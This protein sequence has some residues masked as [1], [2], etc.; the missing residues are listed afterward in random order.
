MSEKNS[1]QKTPNSNLQSRDSSSPLFSFFKISLFIVVL[2]I[3]F[4]IYLENN[5]ELLRNSSFS[6]F[7]PERYHGHS[8]SS[9]FFEGWYYKLVSIEGHSLVVIP[10]IFYGN[11]SDSKEKY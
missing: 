10:G 2:A 7:H 9:N 5:S 1:R 4:G 3:G 8:V 11:E 6:I